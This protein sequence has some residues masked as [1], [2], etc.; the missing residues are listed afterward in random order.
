MKSHELGLALRDMRD[1]RFDSVHERKRVCI[2][3]D[4]PLV[5]ICDDDG[6]IDYTI[7]DDGHICRESH[8]GYSK[9]VEFF[10]AIDAQ[11]FV[12]RHNAALRESANA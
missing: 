12:D 10:D 6:A 7:R 1:C 4:G 2:G 8:G 9:L 5:R 3:W 11:P